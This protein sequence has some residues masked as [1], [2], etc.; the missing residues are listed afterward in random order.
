MRLDAT[1]FP[2]K[3]LQGRWSPSEIFGSS[4]ENA[5]LTASNSLSE[6]LESVVVDIETRLVTLDVQGNLAIATISFH[7]DV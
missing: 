2:F 3:R 4:S 1:Y 6:M 7:S 5:L